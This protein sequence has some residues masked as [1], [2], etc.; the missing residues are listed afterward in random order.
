MRRDRTP[1]LRLT[2][3]AAAKFAFPGWMAVIEHVPTA[4]VVTTEPD[5]VQIFSVDEVKQNCYTERP[6]TVPFVA[7]LLAFS[8]LEL[9]T[10]IRRR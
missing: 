8:W 9:F 10:L 2:A 4:L 7:F 1:K 6:C 3:V 5:T